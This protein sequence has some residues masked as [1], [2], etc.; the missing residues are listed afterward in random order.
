M[1]LGLEIVLH[2]VPKLILLVV[3]SNFM[4]ILPHSTIT[5]LSFAC[6]RRYAS[7]LH[8]RNSITCTVM[9]L[10]MFAAIPYAL[11]DMYL[12]GEILILI[13][14]VISL[15]LYK[16]APADTASRPI[17]GK[18]KRAKLKVKAVASSIFLLILTII[19]STES[20]YVLTAV[21]AIYAVIAI[22][23]CTYFILRRSLNN[24]EQFE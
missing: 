20:F 22:L 11:Q 10:L 18:R 13:F 3:V 6:I 2:N 1:I 24:Y 19:F 12:Y 17:L 14:V 7:G 5:W 4:G 23:P 8:A 16:F 9:T 15:M 21:G